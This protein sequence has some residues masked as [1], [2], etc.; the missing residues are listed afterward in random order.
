[1]EIYPSQELI[2]LS[3][4]SARF[5]FHGRHKVRGEKVYESSDR[6]GEMVEM[7]DVADDGAVLHVR[8]VVDCDHVDAGGRADKDVAL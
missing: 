1:M 4:C 2:P 8:P 6:G 7:T 3:S 5:T